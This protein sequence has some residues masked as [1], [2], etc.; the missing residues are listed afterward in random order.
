MNEL[1][2]EE[3][4]VVTRI[5]YIVDLE[6]DVWLPDSNTIRHSTGVLVERIDTHED[7]SKSV[8]RYIEIGDDIFNTLN[9]EA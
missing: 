6:F 8:Y 2:E 4:E 1:P 3:T 7:G 9:E 5:N